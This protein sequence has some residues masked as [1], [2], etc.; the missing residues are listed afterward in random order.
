[1]GAVLGYLVVVRDES[2]AGA[3]QEFTSQRV[4]YWWHYS[5]Y[6]PSVMARPRRSLICDVTVNVRI[7][8]C[9][10]AL[11]FLPVNRTHREPTRHQS[12]K[13]KTF[14]VDVMHGVHSSS[15]SLH[16][17]NCLTKSI[18]ALSYISL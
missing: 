11:A 1:M 6:K 18:N 2:V 16:R 8:S 5:A 10:K 4:F 13:G 7:C 15:A 14:N 3:G 12:V 17:L 9:Q